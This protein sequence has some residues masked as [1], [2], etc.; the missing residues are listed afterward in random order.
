MNDVLPD[1]AAV[2]RSFEARCAIWFRRYGY[3]NIRMPLVEHDAAVRARHRRGHRHRRARD[4][5]V[6]RRAE[7]R[8]ADAAPGGT[9]A[10]CVRA[11][12][13]H[14][15]LYDAAAAGVVRGPDVPPRAPA[16]GALPPVPPV[17]RRGAG[18][19]R[20]RRRCRADRHVCTRCGARSGSS[21]ITLAINTIGDAEERARYRADWCAISSDHA[22]GSTTTRSGGC[23]PIR[24][25]SSTARIRRC[26][27]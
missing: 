23:T 3:R 10:S 16:E 27:K 20:S 9:P 7:R 1:E 25:A 14:N 11:A 6:R 24:C 4:V 13:Q 5:H 22:T 19:R 18:V 26:R 21:G 8:V 17:R 2:G 12:I 15:L